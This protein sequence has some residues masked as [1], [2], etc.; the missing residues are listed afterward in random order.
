MNSTTTNDVTSKRHTITTDDKI[1]P[2]NNDALPVS[3]MN[4]GRPTDTKLSQFVDITGP[5]NLST[6]LYINIEIFGK[7]TV[8][9]VDTGSERSIVCEKFLLHNDVY[10]FCSIQTQDAPKLRGVNGALI[11]VRGITYLPLK[12]AGKLLVYPCVIAEELQGS[13]FILGLDFLYEYDAQFNVSDKRLILRD[14]C[15][16][17]FAKLITRDDT[18][19]DTKCAPIFDE[20]NRSLSSDKNVTTKGSVQENAPTPEIKTSAIDATDV[21]EVLP[22]S[23]NEVL[24][25]RDDEFLSILPNVHTEFSRDD[26]FEDE[27]YA[28]ENE[29][30]P[31]QI[32]NESTAQE[33]FPL[34]I[35]IRERHPYDLP[36]IEYEI[37]QES[38]E[39]AEIEIPRTLCNDCLQTNE[40]QEHEK[41]AE[42]TSQHNMNTKCRVQL[43][44]MPEDLDLI[45]EI[46]PTQ[47]QIYVK[48]SIDPHPDI[49]HFKAPRETVSDIMDAMTSEQIQDMRKKHNELGVYVDKGHLTENEIMQLEVL[50]GIYSDIFASK[51]SELGRNDWYPVKLTQKE[52]QIINKP[53]FPLGPVSQEALCKAV[54]EM[55]A[56]GII[57]HSESEYN[58]PAFTV[59]KPHTSTPPPGVSPPRR[60]VID[61]RALNATLVNTPF[62]MVT[63]DE[64]IQVLGQAQPAYFAVFDFYSGYFQ[65]ALDE[66]SRHLTSFSLHGG[67]FEFCVVPMGI[68]NAPFIYQRTMMSVLGGMI[69]KNC[70]IYIDDLIC[71]AK[72]FSEMLQVLHEL[73]QR[74]RIANLRLHRKKSKLLVR[75]FL[76]L[77]FEFR[78][79]GSIRVDRRKIQEILDMPRPA[80]VKQIR[81]FLGMTSYNR[82][83]IP[84]HSLIARPLIDLTRK[85]APFIWTEE[86]EKAFIMLK[87]L[88]SSPPVLSLPDPRKKFILSC[89][90]SDVAIGYVLQQ[91]GDDKMPL[92][93]I[94]YGSRC[95]NPSERKWS[96]FAKELYALKTAIKNF[97]VYLVGVQF[98]ARVDCLNCVTLRNISKS[99]NRCARWLMEISGYDFVLKHIPGKQNIIPDFLSRKQP[100]TND[101]DRSA[102]IRRE[103]TK[104]TIASPGELLEDNHRTL[105]NIL[106]IIDAKNRACNET[107]GLSPVRF[108][109]HTELLRPPSINPSAVVGSTLPH[110]LCPNSDHSYY[111]RTNNYPSS[112]A[113]SAI[114]ERPFADSQAASTFTTLSAHTPT[115]L[116]T[117]TGA[118]NDDRPPPMLTPCT[119]EQADDQPREYMTYELIYEPVAMASSSAI[120]AV[121]TQGCM[122]VKQEKDGDTD[123]E[124]EEEVGDILDI[125]EEDV[126]T[127]MDVIDLVAEITPQSIRY[128]Q[129]RDP[130]MRSMIKFIETGNYE[131]N[132]PN[133]MQIFAQSRF[134][135]VDN[136][137]LYVLTSDRP[138]RK[139]APDIRYMVDT[140]K[141]LLVP[142][143]YR[144]YI[145]TQLHDGPC[146][147]HTGHERMYMAAQQFYYWNGLWTSCKNFVKSCLVCQRANKPK[148][149]NK[150]FLTPIPPENVFD[151]AVID[152][153]GPL[154]SVNQYQYILVYIESMTRYPFCIPIRNPNAET[155]A[156]AL[157]QHVWSYIGFPRRISSDRGQQFVSEVFRSVSKYLQ[158]VNIYSTAYHP[159]SQGQVEIFNKTMKT[160][161]RKLVTDSQ[162]N[163]PQLLPSILL[164]YRA[165]PNIT[166]KFAPLTLLTG[167]IPNMPYNLMFD[168]L[169]D[170]DVPKP[171]ILDRAVPLMIKSIEKLSEQAKQNIIDAQQRASEYYNKTAKPH[172]YDIGALVLWRDTRQPRG[173]SRKLCKYFRPDIYV[174]SEA[175]KERHIYRIKNTT[176]GQPVR[177]WIN[178]INLRSIAD[179]LQTLDDSTDQ[180]KETRE[181]IKMTRETQ[182][183]SISPVSQRSVTRSNLSEAVQQQK[184]TFPPNPKEIEDD[185]LPFPTEQLRRTQRQRKAPVRL[186]L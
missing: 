50:V 108:P 18:Q 9:L 101:N 148:F 81:M 12:I 99:P 113:S 127:S 29:D 93:T 43:Q 36:D 105:Q 110:K 83:Y 114:R 68:N 21:Q 166:T 7:G 95:F 57:Q 175:N 42:E 53:Q 119:S 138:S 158:I 170:I 92:K 1:T 59:S 172:H 41:S 178:G 107:L 17:I 130:F 74:L 182:Q 90:A 87:K 171:A 137:V 69:G 179:E 177:G 19:P 89:D 52:P 154:R 118:N 100:Y 60:V 121:N 39:E 97:H 6:C 40:I 183:K 139:R 67:K 31:E 79:D 168:S 65:L 125:P 157:F 86:C 129:N 10:P 133:M 173:L 71:W 143:K 82:R 120:P 159:Q 58:S 62:P 104:Q 161:L 47:P 151:R 112:A 75:D 25:N 3:A 116:P 185:V 91:P 28:I 35:Q 132:D 27:F 34:R 124:A 78:H 5:P 102:K 165:F 14:K 23:P 142:E 66:R 123:S 176:T 153:V 106:H 150:N 149:N 20:T 4:T 8:A 155:T 126:E 184:Q 51:L 169:R 46:N 55:L 54:E 32:S 56:A 111:G 24:S 167:R 13:D 30:D 61:Y 131:P 136:G 70:L 88:L 80:T 33:N 44:E 16:A 45:V 141:Q 73:F 122:V 164:A 109:F 11:P 128:E 77:G 98:E 186:D 162:D 152:F 163:W 134:H 63:Y 15:G 144:H 181:K 135:T 117:A 146:G 76:Y 37:D 84:N 49:A 180:P 140:R 38:E 2:S 96:I 48:H 156:T 72:T 94:A 64:V 85:E 160:A 103:E 174:V 147:G 115:P 22:C 26:D 145:L